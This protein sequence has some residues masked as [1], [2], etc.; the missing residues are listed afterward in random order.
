M[1]PLVWVLLALVVCAAAL[2]FALIARSRALRADETA[3][4]LVLDMDKQPKFRPQRESTI[5]ADGRIARPRIDGTLAKE[6][7]ILKPEYLNDAD[8]PRVLNSDNTPMVMTDPAQYDRIMYGQVKDPQ[9]VYQ[10]VRDIP[11]AVTPDMLKRG[12]ERYNIYCLPCHGGSGYGDGPVSRRAVQLKESGS[13]QAMLWN[14]PTS[15][16]T[17]EIRKRPDGS[18]YN[19]I[20]N[21]AR[22]MAAYGRQVNVLDRWAIVAYV[23]ALETSQNYNLGTDPAGLKPEAMRDLGRMVAPTTAPAKP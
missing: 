4:H 6:D 23:R 12:Q 2:P 18:I 17:D 8:N 22:T 1:K 19:T 15:Y 21:G 11:I 13:T 14:A 7:M 3:P 9:G 20:T 5:F 16:H 10:W